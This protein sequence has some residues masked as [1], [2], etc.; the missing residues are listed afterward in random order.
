MTPCDLLL[1]AHP[2]RS[3]I[4]GTYVLLFPPGTLPLMHAIRSVF[5]DYVLGFLAHC[6]IDSHRSFQGRGYS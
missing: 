2:A 5:L 4:L 3:I 6:A 1:R